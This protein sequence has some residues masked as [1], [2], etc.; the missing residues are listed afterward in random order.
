MILFYCH[1]FQIKLYI[2]LFYE[3]ELHDISNDDSLTGMI[4]AGPINND[5]FHWNAM[6]IGPVKYF[7][8]YKKTLVSIGLLIF[9]LNIYRMIHHMKEEYFF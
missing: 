1:F 7:Y 5:L 8:F 2:Y 6:I 3:Q 4:S 9:I